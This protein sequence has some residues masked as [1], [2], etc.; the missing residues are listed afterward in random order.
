LEASGAVQPG[1]TLYGLRHT[2][3]TVLREL[4]YDDRTIADALGQDTPAMALHY[5]KRADLTKKMDGVS[6]KMNIEMDKRRTKLV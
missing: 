2:Y 1:L 4:G 6:E 5:A 3:A